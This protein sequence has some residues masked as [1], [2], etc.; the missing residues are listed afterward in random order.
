MIRFYE[1]AG[2]SPTFDWIPNVLAELIDEGLRPDF[3]P[4]NVMG[5]D[6]MFV[7]FVD[8]MPVAFMAYR[9]DPYLAKWW[10]VLSYTLPDFRGQGHH[11]ALFEAL[12]DR[13][14]SKGNIKS[15]ES[16]THVDNARA[17]DAF[18]R[19][20]RVPVGL[21][22]SYAVPGTV[23]AAPLVQVVPDH[24]KAF[25]AENDAYRV[26]KYVIVEGVA[27][28]TLKNGSVHT[29][30]EAELDALPGKYPI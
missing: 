28:L 5:N 2:A 20:G 4:M 8:G 3:D 1:N 22:F 17:Q 12:V 29:M 23:E 25:M 7:S 15:I 14:K 30:T 18:A 13:A 24:V 21:I 11:T 10:I 26:M 6:A 19:Q 27:E 16:G 9:P